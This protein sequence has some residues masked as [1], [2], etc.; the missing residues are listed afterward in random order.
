M[1]NVPYIANQRN[2]TNLP[3]GSVQA[4]GPDAFGA[5]LGAGSCPATQVRGM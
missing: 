1:P 2:L 4:P 3:S 5:G